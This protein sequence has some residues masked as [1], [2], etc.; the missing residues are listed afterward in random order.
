MAGVVDYQSGVPE[1]SLRSPYWQGCGQ[2]HNGTGL[3]AGR[4]TSPCGAILRFLC[5]VLVPTYLFFPQTVIFLGVMLPGVEEG[6][7]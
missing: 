5:N 3:K 6:I 2:S 1:G 4:N 7:G